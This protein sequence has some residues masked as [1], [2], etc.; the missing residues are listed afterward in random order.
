MTEYPNILELKNVRLCRP[1]SGWG[2]GIIEIYDNENRQY[3]MET[4]ILQRILRDSLLQVMVIKKR[5]R[6]HCIL[7]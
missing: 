4:Y 1:Y 2:G 6:Y 7:P 5:T 3:W